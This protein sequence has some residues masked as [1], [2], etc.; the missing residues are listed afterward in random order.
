MPLPVRRR[1]PTR[2]FARFRTD[3]TPCWQGGVNLSAGRSSAS[4]SQGA[5]QEPKILIL[6][7]S[8]SAV[9]TATDAAIRA[10]FT[11]K[12]GDATTIIIA[13]RITSVMD[14]DR[15]VVLQDGAIDG[16]GTHEE[17]LAT[18]EIYRDVYTSQQKGV[19]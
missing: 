6:D 7:D 18:N 19:A 10:A 17:L 12:H 3:T 5:G 14:A 11:E 2:S 1:R 16:V 15:I 13:Q 9:D 4:A 8:T